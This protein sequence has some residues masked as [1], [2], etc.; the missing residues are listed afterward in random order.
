MSTKNIIL[1]KP[2]GTL[3]P[4][5][6]VLNEIKTVYETSVKSGTEIHLDDN[7]ASEFEIKDTDIQELEHQVLWSMEM[8]DGDEIQIHPSMNSNYVSIHGADE[9]WFFICRLMGCSQSK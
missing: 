6:D 8:V 2:D 3:R 5:S 1:T 4:I 9:L 7:E